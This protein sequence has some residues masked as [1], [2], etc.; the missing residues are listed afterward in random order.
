MFV[1]PCEI[2]LFFVKGRRQQTSVAMQ[3][4]AMY[5]TTKSERIDTQRDQSRETAERRSCSPRAIHHST[6]PVF[7]ASKEDE[8]MTR[9]A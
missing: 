3:R 8:A 5:F 4:K 9:S 6:R 2:F 1:E 7:V